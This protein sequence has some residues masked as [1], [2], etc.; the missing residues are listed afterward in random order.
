MRRGPLPCRSTGGA[1]VHG[2]AAGGS[3]ALHA[4]AFVNA[5]GAVRTLLDRGADVQ[6][7]DAAGLTPLHWAAAAEVLLARG[8]GVDALS[9]DGST[10][11]SLAVRSETVH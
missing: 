4:A 6:A 8:A 10:P 11:F 2:R 7:T 5:A 3:T 1:H 9:A